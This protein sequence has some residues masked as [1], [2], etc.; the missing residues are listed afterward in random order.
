MVTS[1]CRLCW[2]WG[3]GSLIHRRDDDVWGFL[4]Y[5]LLFFVFCDYIL[6]FLISLALCICTLL[7][8]RQD[9]LFWKSK[10]LLFIFN[11][12]CLGWNP[13]C[14]SNSWIALTEL[15]FSDTVLVSQKSQASWSL[16]DR[17]R[18]VQLQ[19]HDISGS[20]FFL[21]LSASVVIPTILVSKP[22]SSLF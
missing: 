9:P 16:G 2:L 3:L 12:L 1:V 6:T 11:K 19:K 10:S 20:I 18:L 22:I 14:S 7:R 13:K 4:S 15:L 8:G 21:S 5:L 17:P